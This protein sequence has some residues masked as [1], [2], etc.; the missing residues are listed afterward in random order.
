MIKSARKMMLHWTSKALES[1][2]SPD[3]KNA[4]HH[5]MNASVQVLLPLAIAHQHRSGSSTTCMRWAC[6]E[7]ETLCSS[8]R[9]SHPGLKCVTFQVLARGSQSLT[10]SRYHSG[11]LEGAD[12][13]NKIAIDHCD[14]EPD[15]ARLRSNTEFY[16][17][18]S[19]G[20]VQN[21]DS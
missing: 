10:S 19:D 12:K 16:K 17:P 20:G 5:N 14:S 2:Q 3:L 8:S 1:L 15:L 11:D 18:R 7:D 9:Y 21:G 4:A 13:F 6:E